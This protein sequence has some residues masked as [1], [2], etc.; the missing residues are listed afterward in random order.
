MR[1]GGGDGRLGRHAGVPDGVRAAHVREAE[2]ARDILGQ[3]TPL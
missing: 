2:P 1:T 3:P